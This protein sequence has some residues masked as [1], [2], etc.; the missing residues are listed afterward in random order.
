MVRQASNPGSGLR[1]HAD[2]LG[3]TPDAPATDHVFTP[4]LLRAQLV[5]CG[6]VLT[7]GVAFATVGAV[8]LSTLRNLFY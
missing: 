1:A 5:T 7:A 4:L 2:A 3:M 8:D 6:L